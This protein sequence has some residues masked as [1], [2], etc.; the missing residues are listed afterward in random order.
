MIRR[1]FAIATALG[2]ATSLLACGGGGG[3]G[4]DAA[5]P[6]SASAAAGFYLG[7]TNTN[8]TVNAV[9]LD[10][11]GFYVLY[12]RAGSGT[13]AGVVQG[14]GITSG[15][16]LS[17]SDARDFNLEGLGVLPANVTATFSARSSIAGTVAYA[18]G[19][20]SF[21]GTFNARSDAAPTL[22]AVAGVYSGRVS[23]S[24]GNEA[25]TV[26]VAEGG[27]FTGVGTSGCRFTGTVTARARF[28]YNLTVV[29][30]GAPCLFAGQTLSGIGYL[31]S[32]GKTLYAMA[33][34]ATRSDGLIY[35]GSKP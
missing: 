22:A 30:G 29:F 28:A 8:R 27:A 2:L 10:D 1:R 11:G 25:A 17:S 20:T 19:T 3:G 13:I 5:A 21:S 16:T 14:N 31:D 18:A 23:T 7:S 34:N 6:S 35:T 4:G 26:T 15:T 12:S 32:T 24:A 9:V 33:P